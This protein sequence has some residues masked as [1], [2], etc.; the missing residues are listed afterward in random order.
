MS[1]KPRI[2]IWDIETAPM[3]LADFSLG[4]RKQMLHYDNIIQDW[5]IIC[6]AWKWLGEEEVHSVSVLDNKKRYKKNPADDLH[7]C[8]R[9]WHVLDESDLIIAHNGDGFDTKKFNARLFYHGLEPYSPVRSVDTLKALRNRMKLTSNRLDYV[10]QHLGYEGK[11]D[12]RGLWM[13]VMR[14]DAS[15]IEEMREYNKQDVTELENIYKDLL[16]WIHNHP[17]LS[18]YTDPTHEACPRCDSHELQKRGYSYT[19]AGKFQRYQCST[20]G[21]W[22]RGRENL[23]A[24]KHTGVAPSSY[25]LHSQ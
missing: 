3:I 23:L 22:S 21:S 10:A 12:S 11:K 8:E 20:C 17:N 18:S 14:G 25:L 24:K 6:A 4:E 1:D 9:L 15:A 13:R 2:L 7:V 16:P 5:Y 19:N